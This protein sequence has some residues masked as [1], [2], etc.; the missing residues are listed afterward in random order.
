[1]SPGHTVL[2]FTNLNWAKFEAFFFETLASG[3]RVELPASRNPRRPTRT[4]RVVRVDPYGGDGH[5]QK[6]IDFYCTMDDGSEWVFQAKLMPKFGLSDAKNA[7]K[8]ARRK[9]PKST[10]Y[11]L[12]ISGVPNTTAI[13]YVHK[14]PNWEIWGGP[15]FTAHFLR[16]IPIQ[17]Q[18]DIIGRTWPSLADQLVASYYPLRDKV[19]T[20]PDE[21]FAIWLKPDRLFH[22]R[23][24][25][26]GH[27][28]ILD[29]LSAFLRDPTQRAAILVAPGGRGKSRLL[30]ALAERVGEQHP[31][32]TIRFVD[33]LAPSNTPAQSLR[34][35][36]DT[37]FVVVQ[38]DA[39]RAETLRHDLIASLAATQ[40]KLILA[41]RPQALASLEELVV[42]LGFPSNQLRAP[43]HLPKLKLREYEA[44]ALSE[45]EPKHRHHTRF[46]ARMGCDCPLIITVGAS[47]INRN[48]IP[49]DKFEERNFRNEVFARFEGDE[50]NRLDAA[51]PRALV[52]EILQTIAVFSPWLEREVDAKIVA[53]FVGCSETDL[54]AVLTNLEAGQLVVQ[55]GRGRR[56]VPDL[57]SDHLVYTACY[58]DDGALTPYAQRLAGAFATNASQNMLRNLA[59]ADWRATEYHAAKK[60]ASLL[61]PFWQSLWNHFTASDF[62]TRARIVEK[63]GSHSFYQPVRS[64]ELCELAFHLREAAPPPESL[65]LKGETGS[66]INSHQYV[67]DYIP[68]VLEPI[69]IFH[70]DHRERCLDLL[71][72]LA[73]VWPADRDLKD[74]NHPWGVIGRI[75]SFKSDHP[76]SASLGVLAWI[77]KR[78][79]DPRFKPALDRPSEILDKILSPVFARQFDASF[80]EG[81]TYTF[82]H[83]PVS[84]TQTQ[85]MRD[86]AIRIIENQ[87]LPL[88]EMATLNVLPVVEAASQTFYS[89]IGGAFDEKAKRSW[90]PE[91][92]KGLGIL[93]RI[94]KSTSGSIRWKIRTHLRH[95]VRAEDP[96]TK[97]HK[98]AAKSLELVPFSGELRQIAVFC[99]QDWQE[100]DDEPFG[101]KSRRSA[102][103][104]KPDIDRLWK[105]ANEA[106]ARELIARAP[107]VV[108]LVA[109]LEQIYLD[110]DRLGLRPNPYGLLNSFARIDVK[111]AKSLVDHLL[112]K[113][114]SPLHYGWI[115]FLA[116]TIRFPDPW[117]E[118][119][120]YK[121]LHGG[122]VFAT[123]SLLH[124]LP[125][126]IVGPLPPAILKALNRWAKLARDKNAN[127]AV[128]SLRYGRGA[129]DP[130]WHAIAPHLTLNHLTS[131]QLH[132]LGESVFAA[133]KYSEIEA[134]EDFVLCLIAAMTRVRDLKFERGYD[135]LS[136]MS[137]R[138]PRAVY[139]LYHT[140][141]L[142][143]EQGKF[144]QFHALPMDPCPLTELPKTKNYPELVRSLFDSIRA[145]PRTKRWGWTRLVQ[146]A[147]LELSPLAV[148]E[149]NA[150]ARS[151]KSLD[152]L[153][154]IAALFSFEGSLYVLRHPDLTLALLRR[155]RQL[156]PAKY[157]EL[158]ARLASTMGPR[159]HSFTNGKRDPE[160]NYVSDEVAKLTAAGNVAPEL[161]SFYAAVI[162]HDQSWVYRGGD[163][164]FDDEE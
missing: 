149:L 97:L 1:M 51:H 10:R 95:L 24:T 70:D 56:V 59:E 151:A 139:D 36:G 83:P 69:A 44:L 161:Q 19:L 12:L 23:S 162:K 88:G 109:L 67:L 132:T 108:K 35:A 126:A 6:G 142:L 128:G 93:D 112:R 77:E 45:L 21:F 123:S 114:D 92:L 79:A 28:D 29:Q 140:R 120:C 113:K 91:R 65:W 106:V 9:F 7:V 107:Q 89:A 34:A 86:H 87:I 119:T 47:L 84:I 98:H 133:I 127:L 78:L 156:D 74:L 27:A 82:R 5:K 73:G 42:R 62:M 134:P 103:E 81:N 11:I 148:P 135:F 26:V 46:L 60:P 141:I 100:L 76:I 122:S 155:G 150:W 130:F 30:R 68:A 15:S 13:D 63:W 18:I 121:V 137:E 111:L 85:P 43:I 145:R 96:R 116:G 8:K 102:A 55:S 159:V 64:L 125:S 49:P 147:V 39:H 16:G 124:F 75:A 37:C 33:P 57:F 144:N 3:L 61:D 152:E 104:R 38:D 40:G 163:R 157:P 48:Q 118:A 25:L 22:H 94:A 164:M 41:T 99:S 136:L 54:Q 90:Q 17:R 4:C 32:L 72:E 101:L 129:N 50:L 158:E 52:R 115:H 80:S 110:C 53:G 31:D 153:Y 143:S 160:Q 138:F 2:P 105:Q 117:F 71:I 131:D 146:S 154:G 66:R 58:S 14:Q 20:T